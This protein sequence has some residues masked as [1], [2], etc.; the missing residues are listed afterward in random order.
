VN[1]ILWRGKR[2]KEEKHG[3]GKKALSN[4]HGTL[5]PKG[6]A[7]ITQSLYLAKVI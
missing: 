6:R 3:G 4:D 1:L 7:D 5:G 2:R